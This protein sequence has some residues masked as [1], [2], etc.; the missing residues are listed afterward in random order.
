MES[1][2]P[3]ATP[4]SKEKFLSNAVSKLHLRWQT[5]NHVRLAIRNLSSLDLRVTLEMAQRHS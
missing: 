2:Y 4:L 5:A 1:K 3:F